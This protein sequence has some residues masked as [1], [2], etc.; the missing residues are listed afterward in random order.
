MLTRKVS[1]IPVQLFTIALSNTKNDKHIKLF[2]APVLVVLTLIRKVLPSSEISCFFNITPKQIQDIAT[3][4][5]THFEKGFKDGKLRDERTL[6]FTKDL[7]KDWGK[8]NSIREH[9]RV[10]FELQFTL[11]HSCTLTFP[12]CN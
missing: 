12:E 8:D 10:S 7:F 2:K 4:N 6:Y 1:L 5:N 3:S 11:D 9:K